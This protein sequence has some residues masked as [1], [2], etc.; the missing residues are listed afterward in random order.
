MRGPAWFKL[1][2]DHDVIVTSVQIANGF[3]ATDAHGDE[4]LLNSRIANG[5]IRFS[6]GEETAINFTADDRSPTR[7]EVA[8]KPTRSVTVLIDSVH[9]GSRW[10]DL[11]VSE[12]Q[13]R[14]REPP[15][16]T[17]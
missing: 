1:D 17:D 3:Q 2:F 6:D 15:P 9:R 10:N 14:Y 16:A 11:A 12:I 8:S 4:F 5:R 13:V 7:F